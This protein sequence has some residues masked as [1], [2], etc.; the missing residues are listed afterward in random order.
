MV[1]YCCTDEDVAIGFLDIAIVVQGAVIGA[2]QGA[3]A[4]AGARWPNRFPVSGWGAGGELSD[5]PGS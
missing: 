2:Y 1:I 3:S 5:G 4:H